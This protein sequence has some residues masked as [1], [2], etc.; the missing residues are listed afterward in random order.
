[1]N[2]VGAGDIFHSLASILSVSIKNNDHLIL[3]LSQIAGSIA[4]TIEGNER[5]PTLNE[6]RNTLNFYL[7]R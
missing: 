6:I 5:T 4:V 1:M 2:S 7:D 3:L